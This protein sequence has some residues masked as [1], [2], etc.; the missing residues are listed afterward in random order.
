MRLS[1]GDRECLFNDGT[2][3]THSRNCISFNAGYLNKSI[4]RV[5]GQAKVMFHSYFSRIFDLV[6]IK[7]IQRCRIAGLYGICFPC[8]LKMAGAF[9]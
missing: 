9:S 7:P 2:D 5:T 4:D 3:G 1:G 6:Y 8:L